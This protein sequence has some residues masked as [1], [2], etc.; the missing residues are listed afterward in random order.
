M[1]HHQVDVGGSHWVSVQ[2]VQE[3]TGWSISGQRVSSWLQAVE[4]VLS[5]RV[6]AELSSQVVVG[7]VL[8]VL[9]IVL[10]VR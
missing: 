5:V 6:G 10:S 8:W 7:L 2:Q 4:V 9:E 1:A 3:D